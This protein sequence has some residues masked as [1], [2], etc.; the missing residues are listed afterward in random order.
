[1]TKEYFELEHYPVIEKF[2]RTFAQGYISLIMKEQFEFDG[3][4]VFSYS[5]KNVT[6]EQR[7]ALYKMVADS[8]IKGFLCPKQRLPDYYH[9]LILAECIKGNR[10]ATVVRYIEN[11][12]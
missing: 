12:K 1:M 9:N 2:F 6:E 10:Q 8:T 5:T 4:N 7:E 11:N 3:G